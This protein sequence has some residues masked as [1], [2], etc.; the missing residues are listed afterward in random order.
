MSWLLAVETSSDACSVALGNGV[1]VIEAH[2]VEP[3]KHAEL[4]LQQ[5]RKVLAEAGIGLTQLEAI[6]YGRGPG[7]FTGV[8]IATA[9]VQG[10]AYGADLA[11]VPVSS[12]ATLARGALG[13]DTDG[14]VAVAIDAR[15]NEVYF[16]GYA[17]RGGDASCVLPEA[18][19]T[20]AD[21]TLSA[22]GQEWRLVGNGWSRFAESFACVA[23]TRAAAVASDSQPRALDAL[24]LGL[25]A[26]Q[27]GESVPPE[28]ALP[29]Y[30]RNKVTR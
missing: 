14:H 18:V 8:R 9:A 22:D 7:S 26:W 11:V 27:R 3:R 4:V 1:D 2:A 6:V 19:C 30:L 5:V 28:Q 24:A 23:A 16:G 20:P 12:L 21:V 15:M 13:P 10:L 17:M 25:H 29:S